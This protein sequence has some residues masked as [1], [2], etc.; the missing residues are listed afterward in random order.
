MALTKAKTVVVIG[1]GIFV[2]LALGAA[3]ILW[4]AAGARLQAQPGRP[5][6]PK[7]KVWAKERKVEADRIKRLAKVNQTTNATTI[8]LGAFI[9]AQLTDAPLCWKGN[10]ANNLSELPKG[11]H[12]FAGVPFDVSG[13][14]Q[15]MGG[16]LKHYNKQYPASADGI[17]VDRT[18]AR[19]H[20]L[21]GESFITPTNWGTT[22]AKMVVH[23]DNGTSNEMSMVAGEN[24]FDWWY[25]L[26]KTGVPEKFLHL[27]PGTE[28]AWTGSNPYLRKWQPELSVILYRT[29]FDN[30][31]PE[32]KVSS[33]DYVSMQTMTCPFLVGLTVD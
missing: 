8:D 14:V 25:P 15:L 20:L 26:F 9:N 3:F 17:P 5:A 30:P 33:V 13:S 6:N 24:A 16:W 32:L 31:H 11:T 7:E 10:D 28:R 18:C 29:T 21:H 22:V 12:V 23:Y 27:E 4:Q 1:A 19:F 2:L